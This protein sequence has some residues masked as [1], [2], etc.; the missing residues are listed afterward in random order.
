MGE[1]QRVPGAERRLHPSPA[2]TASRP[3]RTGRPADPPA[4]RYARSASGAR[5]ASVPTISVWWV[6]S[7]RISANDVASAKS[8]RHGAPSPD[9]TMLA[10]VMSRCIT[11]RRCIPATARANPSRKPDQ[12]IDWPAASP[13]RPGS[14]P[15]AS[16]STIDP[17]Y[18]GAPPAGRPPPR[19]AAAPASPTSCR[20]PAFRVRPQR[21][22]ADDRALRQ[23][24]P[25]DARALAGVHDF[26]PGDVSVEPGRIRLLSSGISTNGPPPHICL[27]PA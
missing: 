21:L 10:G 25:G 7:G 6:N 23:E 2:R 1:P 16:A 20:S 8:T 9:T 17:G 19:R 27:H 4:G 11:P 24:Q 18:R 5:Y 26:G 13:C 3:A 12:L 15:P 14:P 22:L